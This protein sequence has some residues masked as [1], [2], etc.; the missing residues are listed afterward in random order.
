[1]WTQAHLT[2]AQ[3]GLKSR[4]AGVPKGPE[5]VRHLVAHINALSSQT[6][7]Q[8]RIECYA[9]CVSA[10]VN[11]ER[12]GGLKGKEIS[13]I[14]A[15]AFDMVRLAQIDP[16]TS[17]MAFVAGDVYMAL[18]QIRRKTGDHWLAAWEAEL[19]LRYTGDHPTE[20]MAL[21]FHVAANRALR[22]GNAEQ[23]LECVE[24]A[25]KQSP[26]TSQRNR[27]ATT[28]VS[29][30]K[31]SGLK[32]QAE[33]TIVSAMKSDWISEPT[34]TELQWETLCMAVADSPNEAI[35]EIL[36]RVKVKQSHSHASYVLDAI[37]WCL[38]V[39]TPKY[40][41]KAP[42][43]KNLYRR[44]QIE[45]DRYGNL[46]EAVKVLSEAYES[47][48]PIAVRIEAV[49]QMLSKAHLSFSVERE[50]LIWAAA[51][52]WLDRVKCQRLASLCLS[53]YQAISMQL[54][55]GRMK[56]ALGVLPKGRV[57]RT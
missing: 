26:T 50:L 1:M 39:Q 17:R 45:K 20:G 38:V 31:L 24:R 49:G 29:A 6:T 48:R 40:V 54:S 34:K 30:L 15:L 19:G 27:I 8:S 57:Q 36:A 56:D 9:A 33:K 42:K 12:F 25:L 52:R 18:S 7:E 47:K 22:L 35:E 11:Q 53:Q 44:F 55:N 37:L 3:T 14:A 10:L 41:S 28:H 5:V 51:F 21:R 16:E 46:F 23:A 43:V 32:T 4:L 2:A 13:T